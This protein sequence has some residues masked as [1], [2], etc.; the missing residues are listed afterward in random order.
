VDITAAH[1]FYD[2]TQ[3]GVPGWVGV[4]MMAQTIGVLAGLEAQQAGQDVK[5]GYL[6]GVRRYEAYQPYFSN[7]SS[8]RIIAEARYRESGGVNSFFCQIQNEPDNK[9]LAEASLL[10]F[11]A[12]E[13]V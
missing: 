3:Q 6:I 11:E 8:L 4:E 2:V 10:V 7:N 1:V 12:N 13:A 9:L 5:V